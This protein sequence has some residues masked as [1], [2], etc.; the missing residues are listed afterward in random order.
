MEDTHIRINSHSINWLT[1]LI[2]F[3]SLTSDLFL[4]PFIFLSCKIIYIVSV[5]T[6]IIIP[7]YTFSFQNVILCT[8]ASPQHIPEQHLYLEKISKSFSREIQ[9]VAY[10]CAWVQ[11]FFVFSL[12][13]VSCRDGAC[14]NIATDHGPRARW[15]HLSKLNRGFVASA[16]QLACCRPFKCKGSVNRNS[17]FIKLS[18]G[19]CI[20]L[21]HR[22]LQVGECSIM[23]S[24]WWSSRALMIPSAY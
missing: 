3:Q 12:V 17:V 10:C 11:S 13:C 22:Y 18:A 16:V 23:L 21:P 7:Y 1:A 20:H 19:F 14:F 2:F 5:L 4:I 24:E 9:P 6:Q 8:C 15:H